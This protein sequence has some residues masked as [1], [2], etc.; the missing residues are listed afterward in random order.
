MNVLSLQ[1]WVSY[2]HVGNAAAMF[3]L[4]RLGAEVWGVH[5]VQFSNHTGY[6]DWTGNVFDG[7]AISALVA[8]IARRGVLPACD[9][10]LSGYLGAIDLGMALL[11][12]VR[13]VKRANPR[14]L[15]CCDPV[16]GDEGR[17][18]VRPGI[19]ELLRTELLPVADI[20]TP[21]S[22]ELSRLTGSPCAT[23]A[24]AKQAVTHLQ[25]LGPRTVLV[26]SLRTEATPPDALDLLV[27]EN[28]TFCLLRTPLLPV[29]VN[30]AGDMLAAL[31]L[32]H[33]LATGSARA[34]LERASSS[35]FGVIRQ[36]A[37]EGATEL[38]IIAAQEELIRPSRQFTAH[39]C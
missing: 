33:R 21:N 22:F 23:L 10:V 12:A 9:A 7:A 15:Y 8:G 16:I 36:T 5:T 39:P 20:A 25:A 6:A 17:E 28:N 2:G 31:F 35:L 13:Q 4:Q 29:T 38:A 26:T 11:D 24:A 19:P 37:E 1:S 3:P 18:Y 27:G 32:Y 34:A 30:G 14:A